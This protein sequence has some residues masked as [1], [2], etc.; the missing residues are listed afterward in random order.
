MAAPRKTERLTFELLEKIANANEYLGL[1]NW[2]DATVAFGYTNLMICIGALFGISWDVGYPGAFLGAVTGFLLAL[3]VI[4][5][6]Q[7][8]GYLFTSISTILREMPARERER[9]IQAGQKWLEDEIERPSLK[10]GKNQYGTSQAVDLITRV[11]YEHSGIEIFS[12]F[13]TWMSNLY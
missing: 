9:M 10:F 12:P 7:S 13:P 6:F 2:R 11:Y 1:V 5:N 4:R 8:L 3:R